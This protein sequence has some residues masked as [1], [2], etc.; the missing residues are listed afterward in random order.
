MGQRK[1]V[2]ISDD[3]LQHDTEEEMSEHEAH[4]AAMER[5]RRYVL[6]CSGSDESRG[7]TR[8]VNTIADYEGWR[9]AGEPGPEIPASELRTPIAQNTQ[10]AAE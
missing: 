9:R 2:W 10:A 3:G 4:I 7:A 8:I 1:E 6:Y 5:A